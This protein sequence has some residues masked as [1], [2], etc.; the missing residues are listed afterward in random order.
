MATK[1]RQE[2]LQGTENTVPSLDAIQQLF[3]A[4]LQAPTQS[5][6]IQREA[7]VDGGNCDVRATD[8]AKVLKAAD[9]P[10][11]A[12]R[13][14]NNDKF[15]TLLKQWETADTVVQRQPVIIRSEDKFLGGPES[16][17]KSGTSHHAILF[18]AKDQGGAFYVG[19][20]PD[21][22]ATIESRAAWEVAKTNP[23]INVATS[24]MVLGPNGDQ[25]GPLFRKYYV[26]K[27]NLW[28]VVKRL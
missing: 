17:F 21:V 19:Y 3:A 2:S 11:Q 23:N 22:T 25:L 4:K 10:I 12:A 18:V 14:F 1:P 7:V 5:G 24:A 9:Q 20:D 6:W 15:S 16:R 28:P 8:L 27:E 13:E 26:D